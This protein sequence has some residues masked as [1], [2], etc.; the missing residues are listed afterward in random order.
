M[1]GLVLQYCGI[2]VPF[3]QFS[4]KFKMNQ[5]LHP[6]VLYLMYW[7]SHLKPSP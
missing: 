4:L 2:F 5:I 1:G 3:D 6:V 7:E